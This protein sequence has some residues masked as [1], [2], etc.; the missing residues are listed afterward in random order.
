MM[1]LMRK[2]LYFSDSFFEFLTLQHSS[3]PQ[4]T[5]DRH[6]LPSFL[7]ALSSYS[8]C[9]PLL[10]SS[11]SRV[12]PPFAAPAEFF[13]QWILIIGAHS[14]LINDLKKLAAGANLDISRYQ[15]QIFHL[16]FLSHVILDLYFHKKES[17]YSQ[18]NFSR[19]NRQSIAFEYFWYYKQ[20][21]R[22]QFQ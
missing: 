11:P 3:H 12:R 13:F 7:A 8:S 18:S 9:S 21:L 20:T 16:F 4:K 22:I 19:F 6:F 2:I 17:L 5:I 10:F 15:E 1:I 14:T